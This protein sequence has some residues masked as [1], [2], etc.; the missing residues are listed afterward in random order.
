MESA[1]AFAAHQPAPAGPILLRH[2]SVRTLNLDS[3][4]GGSAM[5]SAVLQCRTE[6]EAAG[7]ARAKA[8]EVHRRILVSAILKRRAEHLW[9]RGGTILRDPRPSSV[10]RI[11]ALFWQENSAEV[12]DAEPHTNS[13]IPHST[14]PLTYGAHT[15]Y[16]AHATYHADMQPC[17]PPHPP[18]PHTAL[19][20][21][22]R[23]R[24]FSFAPWPCRLSRSPQD[25]QI[26][27]RAAVAWPIG[28]PRPPRWPSRPP[29][30]PSSC[31]CAR[32]LP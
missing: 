26:M 29:R 23:Y 20:A 7:S 13:K 31:A 25:E 8:P 1:Y 5:V 27:P 16:S 2:T 14:Q 30:S 9:R 12:L 3:V 22:A 11:G 10:A 32:P 28:W 4:H 19:R 17:R 21:R 6:D 18:D 24:P 15:E